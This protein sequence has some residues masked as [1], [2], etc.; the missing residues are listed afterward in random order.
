MMDHVINVHV[1]DKIAHVVGDPLYV[2]GNSDYTVKFDFDSEW[3]GHETKTARFVK[4][5]KEYIDVVFTGDQCAMPILENTPSVRIG[6]YAGNLCTTTAAVVNAQRS[7]LCGSGAPADPHPDVYAQVMQKMDDI[8]AAMPSEDVLT[9]IRTNRESAEEAA[10]KAERVVENIPDD[11]SA[12]ADEIEQLTEVLKTKANVDVD[13]VTG[14]VC[15]TDVSADA[16]L[17]GLALYGKTVQD[18]APT[19]ETPVP[20]VTAGADGN[21]DVKILG[22][23]L[24]RTG[25]IGATYNADG[26]F[27]IKNQTGATSGGLNDFLTGK[28]PRGTYTISYHAGFGT[29]YMMRSADDYSTSVP[30]GNSVTFEYDGVSYLRFITSNIPAN[31]NATYKIQLEAGNV[32]SEFVPYKVGGSLTIRTPNGLRGIPVASGGNYTDEHGQQ[33]ICD[34]VD[35]QRGVYIQRCLLARLAP[36]T[37]KDGMRSHFYEAGRKLYGGGV[38]RALCNVTDNYHYGYSWDSTHYYVDVESNGAIWAFVP[39]TFGGTVEVLCAMTDPIET[40]IPADDLAAYHTMTSIYPSTTIYNDVGVDMRV[41]CA[42]DMRAYAGALL[43]EMGRGDMAQYTHMPRMM[44]AGAVDGMTKDNAVILKFTYLGAK[45]YILDS[46]ATGKR[47]SGIVHSGYAKVKWQG[48]SSLAFPKKNYT[49]TLYSDAA[50][51]TKMPI[52][53]KETWGAQS[54]YCMKANFIDPSHCRNVIAAKLWAKC[55]LSRSAESPSYRASH[56]LPNAG[57]IDGY[58]IL[59]FINDEYVGLYTMNIPKDEWMFGMKDGEGTNVVLCGENYVNATDFFAPSV[60]DGSDWDYEVSPADKSWVADS[61][62]RIYT[63]L[64]MSES[65]DEAIA[66]K[67]AAI[68]NCLDVHSVIDY[69]IFLQTVCATDNT[70]KNQ[71]MCTVD[72][73]H[74]F[75]SAYDLDTAFGMHWSGAKY[76]SANQSVTRNNLLLVIV[77]LYATEYNARKAEL[78][79]VLSAAAVCEMVDNFLIDVPQEAF[80]LEAKLWPDMC[81]ANA[82]AINQIKTFMMLRN[83]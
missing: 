75:I 62:N 14:S 33:W 25:H 41:D 27:T 61:F 67:K 18:G 82:N 63:A 34:E 81:G 3:A 15:T 37:V 80:D 7:I 58:P 32:G 30:L 52:A 1:I 78:A 10:K 28:L 6:V 35:F 51:T 24:F 20:L 53:L 13:T 8:Y 17:Q 60:V 40:P 72:G 29:M 44:F 26:T 48:S 9:E 57:A 69:D 36:I 77:R 54:K 83:V 39:E 23:N 59:T 68:E 31:T 5:N 73:T 64:T 56:T 50:C 70:G 45:N 42:V 71:L 21:I 38:G 74:W 11:Y 47:E 49:V 55:V 4:N 76:F 2:C 66:A 22:K 79:S 43:A 46:T 16:P 12:L 19:P 65:S